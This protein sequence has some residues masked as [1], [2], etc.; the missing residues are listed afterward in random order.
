MKRILLLIC[1][2]GLISVC[3]F[4]QPDQK[5]LKEITENISHHESLYRHFHQ[6]PELSFEEYKTTDRILKSK[7]KLFFLKKNY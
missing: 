3:T 7:S 6:N 5:I 4:S 2:S 1:V